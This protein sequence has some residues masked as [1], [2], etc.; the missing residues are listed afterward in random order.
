M[1]LQNRYKEHRRVGWTRVEM[2]LALYEAAIHSARDAQQ[3]MDEQDPTKACQHCM[4]SVRLVMELRAG[5]NFDHGD[6]PKQLEQLL[7]FVQHCLLEREPRVADALKILETLH[8]AYEG[9]RE[10]AIQLESQGVI[11][12]VDTD[13][14][15]VRRA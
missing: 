9:I 3:A 4:R 14:S 10:E 12:S 6:S 7:E 5:L 8:S 13:T 15:V 1:N 11:P 2:L